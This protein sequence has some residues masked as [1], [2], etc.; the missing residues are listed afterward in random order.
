MVIYKKELNYNDQCDQ[1]AY[2]WQAGLY[3]HYKSRYGD[4]SSD[5]QEEKSRRWAA[6]ERLKPK[7]GW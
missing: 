2:N 6:A 7:K 5:V 4:G 3:E 1:S